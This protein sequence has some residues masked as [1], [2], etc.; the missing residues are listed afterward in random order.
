MPC[1]ERENDTCKT[2]WD[3]C[4]DTDRLPAGTAVV[5]VVDDDGKTVALDAKA[6]MGMKELQT[7]VVKGKAKRD[8]AGN[9]VV[10]APAV[11]VKK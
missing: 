4:C 7:I 3:Y 11:F 2:P 10:L 5:K 1:S 8:E 6:A 9:L